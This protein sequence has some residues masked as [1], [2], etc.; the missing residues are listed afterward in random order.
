MDAPKI[1]SMEIVAVKP[2]ASDQRRLSHLQAATNRVL[3]PVTYVVKIYLDK[4]MPATGSGFPLYVGDKRI[5]RYTEFSGG[6]YFKV[7]DPAFLDA[8]RRA[9]V[10]F[11]LEATV[12]A[13]RG[14]TYSPPAFPAN[15]T[16]V[17]VADVA[18][19]PS[20]KDV[21]GH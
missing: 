2:E 16:R 10:R 13:V 14:L 19:L 20:L 7:H 8:Q 6:V 15:S 18:G 1:L 12:R 4:P 3:E 21:L 9:P 5:E 11:A 17:A